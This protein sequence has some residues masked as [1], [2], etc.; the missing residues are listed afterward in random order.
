MYRK[1]LVICFANFCTA[2][3]L[4]AQDLHLSDAYNIALQHNYDILIEKNNAQLTHLANSNGMAGGLPVVSANVNNQESLISVNQKLN[5]GTIIDRSGI[6]SNNLNGNL[7]AGWLLYNGNRVV[8]AQKRLQALEAQSQQVLNARIQNTIAAVTVAYFDVIRQQSLLKTLQTSL[9]ISQKQLD[10]IKTRRQVGLATEADQFQIQIDLN[11][12]EQ[13][14]SQ[15]EAYIKQTRA[16]LNNLLHLPADTLLNLTDSI[17]INENLVYADV[18]NRVSANPELLALGEQIKINEYL[19]KEAAAL[20]KPSLNSFAGINYLQ[21]KAGAGQLLLNQNYGPFVGLGIS[22]PVYNGGNSK[23]QEQM[24]AV[25]TQTAH[26]QHENAMADFQTSASKVYQ[27]YTTGLAQLKAQRDICNM[28]KQL[29]DLALQRF[30]LSSAT[31]LELREA[32]KSYEASGFH[33]IQ[34]MY[35]TKLAETE[36][37]RISNQLSL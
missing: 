22:I 24:A 13:D 10:I 16:D 35:N 15:Q 37:K 21:A 25:R 28:S 2:F 36:L 26:L 20:R 33:L 30:Q 19:Q 12:R 31:I 6:A 11:T 32:Q 1:I 18:L 9:A 8:A 27:A 17:T 7:T 14:I 34:L 3:S 23:R 5:N 29:V 4:S